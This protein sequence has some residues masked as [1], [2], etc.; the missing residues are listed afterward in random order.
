MQTQAAV[1]RDLTQ[2]RYT[3]I[4]ERTA[5]NAG[6]GDTDAGLAISERYLNETIEN[7][8]VALDAIKR[9]TY[10][11]MKDIQLIDPKII[12]LAGLN[13]GI[14]SVSIC[15]TLSRTTFT[16]GRVLQSEVFATY[17]RNWDAIKA[18]KIRK[19]CM[20][21]GGMVA[22]R[23]A[24]RSIANKMGFAQEPW[25][26]KSILLAGSWLLDILIQGSV[27]VL[28]SN[29]SNYDRRKKTSDGRY[30]LAMTEEAI[31]VARDIVDAWLNEH[32]SVLPLLHKPTLWQSAS[33]HIHDYKLPLVRS[34]QKATHRAVGAAISAGSMEGTLRA[35]NTA[36]GVPW[37]INDGILEIVQWSYDNGVVVDGIP[38]K[39]DLEPPSRAT[40]WDDMSETEQ[41]LWRSKASDIR[42]H[43]HGLL[44]GRLVFEHAMST[45]RHLNG[46]GF[47]V[48]MNLDYRGRMYG[49][50]SFQYQRQDYIRAMFLFAHGKPVDEMGLY[51]LKVHLANCGDFDRVSK[52]SFDER[53]LW[54]DEQTPNIED[55]ANN[56]KSNLW[57]TKA[58][59]PFMFL[60]ACQEYTKCLDFGYICRLPVSFD[61]SCSGLQ[62]LGAMTRDEITA[63]EV[64]LLP[65]E[66]PGDIY[67]TVADI[68]KKRIEADLSSH[69]PQTSLA[70]LCLDYG[71]TR[72][73]VKRNVMT[74]SY[75]SN[76]FGMTN[77]H[78]DDTM[79][80]LE[81]KVLSGE[82]SSHPFGADNGWKAARYLAGHVYSAIEQVV[83]RPA[84]AMRFLRSIARA[85]GHEG[86][87]VVWHTPLGFPV[88]L[89]Y[90]RSKVE[91]IRLYLHNKGVRNVHRVSAQEDTVGIDKNRAANAIAPGFVHSLDA[92]HLQ[93]VV[94]ACADEGITNLAL[95]HDS[96]GCLPSD[97][98]AVRAIIV[99]EFHRM[100]TENDVLADIREEAL[101]QIDNKLRIPDV[102]EYGNLDLTQIL[103]ADY[104]FS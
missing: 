31:D 83:S 90:P 20:R 54:V 62:H 72:S 47:Y 46:Q 37:V 91:E 89:S 67:S 44:G 32:P 29:E 73:L 101:A 65:T 70:T 13:A 60:A 51:W 5:H 30:R 75:S 74:Y 102:P 86:K 88:V 94:N 81:H 36:Q 68:T 39:D 16:L 2:D 17:L 49:I 103:E 26:N 59:K 33:T 27:F 56:P 77:Q 18:E 79:A 80:P 100:Y 35:V 69:L 95:V 7:V 104:A 1:V 84:D 85:L 64:N 19:V 9:T 78:R 50:P 3:R 4:V 25:D 58:D 11:S 10:N 43:N 23:Q 55:C 24:A 61:G 93:M 22:R 34:G 15:D 99:K 8:K 21:R 38:P 42:R 45:A 6:Y 63:K 92:C 14:G 28:V 66:T 87:P 48:P 76:K 53:V 52:K 41:R 12:A 82:L 97:A 40:S 98:E 71:I 57:W 96:F